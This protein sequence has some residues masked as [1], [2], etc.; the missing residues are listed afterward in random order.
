[1]S[2]DPWRDR[3]RRLL[4]ARLRDGLAPSGDPRPH[5]VVCGSDPLAYRLV[6][7]LAGT[8]QAARITA[9]VP[10][11][12]RTDMPDV[13]RI[14]GIR[15]IRAE[16]IDEATLRAAG[17]AG[18][19]A[20]ALVHADDVTNIHAAL[21][22]QE[23]EPDLRLVIRMFNTSLGQGVKRLFADCTVLS[24]AAMAAPAF[25]AAALGEV[26]PTHFRHA[27][28]T[29]YVAR[30][31]DV[32][33]KHVVCLLAAAASDG[34]PAALLPD[35]PVTP[36]PGDVVLA[37]ATGR[38]AG[39]V[40]AARR[41]VRSRR[42][43]RPARVLLRAV[44]AM[45]D[46]RL[47]VAALVVALVVAVSG[48]ILARAT[49]VGLWQAVYLTLLTAVSGSDADLEH[50]AA[51]Q[52]VQL[53]LTLAGLALVPLI[54]AAVVGAVLNARLALADERLRIPRRD[55]VVVVGLGN[56]GTRVIRQL[57]DLGIEVVAIDKNAEARGA[58]VAR[59]LDIPFIVGDAGR[60][61]N[62]R[63]A[64]V[65]TCQALVVLS[66]DDVTNLKAALN[67][68]AIRPDLRVVLRLFD[69]EFAARIQKA[70]DITIS[71][72]V[73]YLAAPAFAYAIRNRDVIATIPLE[74][75]VL[76]V[77]EVAVAAGSP[78]VGA[79][80]RAAD[81]PHDVRVIGLTRAGA[82]RVVW[83]LP[84]AHRLAAGDRLTVVSRRAGLRW[85][86]EQTSPPGPA[87]GRPQVPPGSPRLPPDPPGPAP[88][89]S[90]LPPGRSRR[91]PDAD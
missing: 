86:L 30:R 21:C 22:A 83:A 60:E 18:A 79:D 3:A 47:G 32:H 19:D 29:L 12:R 53:L 55:H 68:R 77:A 27:G 54:T 78:L 76:L 89:R 63:L 33:P 31:G 61:E 87:P 82:G 38:P 36:D 81:R 50:G 65:E 45:V 14:R 88:D 46:R 20:L 74:R 91:S 70:F 9:I 69:G 85:L 24:D 2:G 7:E 72:S 51:V 44:R 58:R 35:P 59:Q 6:D 4:T 23:V 62:L 25:V 11:R 48:T 15:V 16:R 67:G 28:R 80:L 34:P 57:T 42:R 49:G 10:P 39:T 71:R 52:L 5:Y 40:M 64:S 73:S 75:H 13:G 8:G 26:D 37:E 56:V 1:M 90:S 41:I 66:T 43:R 84:S 17:L